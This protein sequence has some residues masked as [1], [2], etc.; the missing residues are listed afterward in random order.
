MDPLTHALVGGMV[1]KSVGTSRRRFWFMMFL[2]EAPDLDFLLSGL[3]GWAAIF[4]H[5]GV[6]HS[7]FGIV[8]QTVLYAALF[9]RWDRGSF[10]VRALQYSI[11]LILHVFCDYLTSFGVPLLSPFSFRDFSADLVTGLNVIPAACMLIGLAWVH[12]QDKLGWRATRPMWA[13][14]AL[15]LFLSMSGKAYAD[16]CVACPHPA[17]VLPTMYNP[18]AW[19]AVYADPTT[20]TYHE[21]VVDLWNGHKTSEAPLPMPNGDF[22]VQASMKSSGVQSFLRDNRW[23]LVRVHQN[24]SGWTVQWG[25]LLFS[26]NGL[27]RGKVEVE[28]SSDGS[29][30]SERR[31]F[32]F[33]NPDPV[34]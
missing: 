10:R 21:D 14:W 8:I 32:N 6:T 11:P 31:I 34:S 2:G 17:T 13:V 28:I 26:H 4:H 12:Y 24:H 1:A 29:V 23:P 25:N 18:L 27:V 22:P 7:L 33:W 16:K 9:A 15:Y 19:R 5:R 3:G 20:H 30:L